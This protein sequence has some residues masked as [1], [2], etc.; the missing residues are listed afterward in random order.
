MILL[1]VGACPATSVTVALG[2]T[3]PLRGLVRLNEPVAAMSKDHEVGA[4]GDET[5]DMEL[6][7]TRAVSRS[8]AKRL[9]SSS[10][11][12][13]LSVEEA[14]N[15][16]AVVDTT[17]TPACSVAHDARR[18]GAQGRL[19]MRSIGLDLGVH[20]IEFCEVKDGEVVDRAAVRNLLQLKSRLGPMSAPAVVGFEACREGWYV[21]DLLEQ[22]GHRPR[23]LDTT[24]VRQIGVGQH[25]R[26]ND[27]I[28]ARVIALAIEAGR[29]AEAHVLSPERRVLRAQLSVRGALVQT[30]SQYVTTIRGLA[31]AAGILLPSC[32][33]GGFLQKVAEAEIGDE[34][35]N[36]IAPLTTMLDGLE[37]EIAAVDE[38]L[39]KLAQED[40]TISLCATAPGVGLIVAATF[41]SV[42]DEAK[43]FRNSHGVAAY[44][45]LVP[46]ESTTGGPS[47][48]RLGGITKQG[49]AY[50]RTMLIQSAWTILRLR[51][52]QDPLR[53]W[54]EHIAAT[55]GNKIA[56]VAL[57]RKL[58]GV[59]W[60]MLRD[61]TPYD[62][63]IEAE[64]SAVGIREQ[65]TQAVKRACSLEAAAKKLRRSAPAADTKAARPPAK[66]GRTERRRKTA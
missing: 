31:R 20:H 1:R 10:R 63:A 11:A 61:G 64:Q 13:Q 25:K 27:K 45:G 7:V 17:D 35:R 5:K 49:N 21:H 40:P 12:G 66:A 19:A 14:A 57:A 15:L 44:L 42:I 59:L 6:A 3:R 47:K 52:N 56:V 37:R 48:R 60:A 16:P 50:A 46:S 53:K 23:M 36:R 58:A 34:L 51:Q 2:D 33:T 9:E 26:K 55:R 18:L 38:T 8:I 4:K 22:W 54:A 29:V 24:R 28:D 65:A 32:K 43:R 30:R 62:G 39:S 41:V